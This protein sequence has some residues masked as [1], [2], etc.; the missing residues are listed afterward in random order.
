[1]WQYFTSNE[2]GNM[3]NFIPGAIRD[4]CYVSNTLALVKVT[5][6][7]Q[8]EA[9]WKSRWVST[10][11]GETFTV[12][13]WFCRFFF[14]HVFFYLLLPRPLFV[15]CWELCINHQVSVITWTSLS[16]TKPFVM[17]S[18]NIPTES[19][20]V[21][22]SIWKLFQLRRVAQFQEDTYKSNRWCESCFLTD[23]YSKATE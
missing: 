20:A 12:E 18:G 5:V 21:I 22:T 15:L 10:E 9:G 4:F 6:F 23:C 14:F 13:V 2:C 8:C 3:R 1:M 17:C 11:R 19:E 16:A 7:L